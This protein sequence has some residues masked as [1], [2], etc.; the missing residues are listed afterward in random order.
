MI[1]DDV[2]VLVHGAKLEKFI[3]Y[4][5]EADLYSPE[6]AFQF[7]CDAKYDISPGDACEIYV[8]RIRVMTGIIDTITRS[9]SRQGPR[10]EIQG[11]S[12]ASILAD[13][14]VTSFKT[15][16][17]TLPALAER[18]VRNLPFVGRKDF[19]YNSGSAQVKVKRKFLELSP[20]DTVFDVLKKAANSQGYLF[21][22]APDGAF[23]FDKP[24]ETGKASFKIHAFD[25]KQD[26]IEGSVT[27]TLNDRHSDIVIMGESQ[28]DDDIKYVC[29]KLKNDDFP[30]TRPL[31]VSWNENE[32][33]A[34]KTA[35]LRLSTEKAQA[36]Q[37][38]YTLPGH[39]QNGANWTINVFC[40]V[41]DEY[42]GAIGGY[43]IKTRT[44]SLSRTDGKRTK[45]TL[46][47]GGL[48]G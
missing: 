31:V 46:Q 20:G 30:F 4:T 10:I 5:I 12:N 21:F 9:L 40:N 32:G 24:A 47:P 33:P 14:C 19:R 48:L 23:V 37:L 26:Y 27:K 38:E 11:R 43:L 1:N 45:I 25:G 35:Q 22:A 2:I 41:R 34:K 42:N 28:D 15:L 39:S 8:N 7:E 3:S 16:P 13:S 17:I 36:I 6:G 44:F 29:A 18:L